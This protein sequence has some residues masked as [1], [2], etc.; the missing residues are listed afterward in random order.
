MTEATHHEG[1]QLSGLV[2]WV[3]FPP[4]QLTVSVFVL[5]KLIGNCPLDLIRRHA[6]IHRNHV[7]QRLGDSW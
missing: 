7:L 1:W 3:S 2:F 5:V 6:C 4:E